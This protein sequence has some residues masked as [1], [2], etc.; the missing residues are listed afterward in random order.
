MIPALS[1][2]SCSN[3]A[4]SVAK[5]KVSFAE[6]IISGMIRR[7]I[8]PKEHQEHAVEFLD[9]ELRRRTER[10]L[11]IMADEAVLGATLSRTFMLPTPRKR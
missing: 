10:M 11:R 8:V 4:S 7:G 9:R 1:S 6:K 2:E 3:G 5:A